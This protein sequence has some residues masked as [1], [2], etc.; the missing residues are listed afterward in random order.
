M[1]KAV[2]VRA[3]DRGDGRTCCAVAARAPDWPIESALTSLAM[4]VIM[5]TMF[6]DAIATTHARP[7]KPCGR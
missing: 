3:V 5:R 2:D 1:P 7:R 4:D 6:S